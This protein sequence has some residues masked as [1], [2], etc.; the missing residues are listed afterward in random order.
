MIR[1]CSTGICATSISTPRSPRATITASAACTISSSRS[2]ASR[3]SILA[4]TPALD[5]ADRTMS[6]SARTSSGERTKLKPDE[7]DARLRRPDRVLMIG[8]R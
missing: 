5:P 1:F 4:T 2:S 3:F 6:F 7:I 8:R